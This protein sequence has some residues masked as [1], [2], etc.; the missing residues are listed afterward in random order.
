[1]DTTWYIG[2]SG[3][4]YREWKDRFYPKGL[5]QSKWLGYYASRFN[6]LEINNTFYRFPEVKTLAAFY[7]KTPPGFTFAV[8]VPRIITHYKQFNE[9]EELVQQFYGVAQEGLKEK[10][11]PVLFQLPPQA[12]YTPERL[13]RI[14]RQTNMFFVNVIEFRHI[15]WWR[16]EVISALQ[17]NNITFCGVSFPGLIQD[18][19]HTNTVNYYRFHGKP[20]LYYSAYENEFLEKVVSSVKE[21]QPV[22][23]YL[24]FNNTAELAA[25]SNGR[26]VQ[27]LT[28]TLPVLQE[29]TLF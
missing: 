10:L 28:G 25:I 23:A 27:S 7:Q 5:A 19:M 6:T 17:E 26:H 11:G 12:V 14:I 13:D 15:S 22:S 24:Y 3:F 8:K 29:N 21:Y 1:M 2:C 20:K 16:K 9:T 4:Y 18:T